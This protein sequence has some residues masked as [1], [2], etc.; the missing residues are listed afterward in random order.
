MG[1]SS[2]PGLV[3]AQ[4]SVGNTYGVQSGIQAFFFILKYYYNP[5]LHWNHFCS[6]IVILR[7]AVCL[8]GCHFVSFN[9]IIRSAYSL[10]L[11]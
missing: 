4:P 2:M 7:P 3:Q 9:N 6:A 8:G 10:H 11:P 1:L 5:A